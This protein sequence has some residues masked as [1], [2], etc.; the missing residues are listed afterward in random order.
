M[1]LLALSLRSA[2]RPLEFCSGTSAQAIQLVGI[3]QAA[4]VMEAA[5]ALVLVSVKEEY[6]SVVQAPAQVRPAEPAWVVHC[7]PSP[8]LAEGRILLSHVCASALDSR[9]Y[10]V[11]ACPLRHTNDCGHA[12]AHGNGGVRGSVFAQ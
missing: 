7:S 10:N 8:Y 2:P 9:F 3:L 5:A 12:C 1:V 4:A 11:H 6:C